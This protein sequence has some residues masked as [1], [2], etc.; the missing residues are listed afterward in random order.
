[1]LYFCRVESYFCNKQNLSRDS[2]NKND[3]SL[4]HE[5]MYFGHPQNMKQIKF[6]TSKKIDTHEIFQ[7]YNT[8]KYT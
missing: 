7:N 5:D 4:N 6:D 2:S 1:M 3:T 8:G